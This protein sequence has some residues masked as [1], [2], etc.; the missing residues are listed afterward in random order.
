MAKHLFVGFGFGPIQSGLFA[1]EAF[2]SRRFERIVIAEIDSRLV[3]A[4][5]RAGGSYWV[6]I[7]A[8]DRIDRQRVE[9]VEIYNPNDPNDRAALQDALAGATEIC[10]SLPSVNFY[11][12]GSP[13]VADWIAEGL[14]KSAA[15]A[16]IVYTAEN[17]N[18][19]AEILQAAVQAKCPR[20]GRPVQ[21]LNTVIGK[22]SQVVVDAAYI[23]DKKLA[24]I[25]DGFPRA[26]LV[27]AFNKILVTQCQL[28]DFKP[29]ISVFI[30]KPDLL[31]F[32]E[33]K[34]YGHNAIHALLAYLAARR[35]LRSM[36]Q[37]AAQPDLMAIGRRAFIEQSGAA[38][39]AKYA[40]LGDPLFTPEGFKDYAEDLLAR[41]TNPQLDD[42]VERAAR[43]PMRKLGIS[44]RLFGTM[45]LCLEQSVKPLDLAIGAAG[46]LWYL[47]KTVDRKTLPQEL[48]NADA[49]KLSAG[50]IETALRWI[51][52]ADGQKNRFADAL[53]G[54]T[55]QAYPT[56]QSL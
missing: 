8:A 56:L 27:E 4:V 45:T 38:L 18:H 20:F 48:A 41:M 24:P 16:T 33:A 12:T 2:A 44:D 52:Q 11:T 3:E 46:G 30:E 53:V 54:L 55:Q 43:D 7:A 14:A 15:P 6:N 42:A 19:A 26:F 34:L 32:E 23:A 28:K 39:C 37:L 50:Q 10:T 9:G 51:W 25:A 13:S 47:L 36:A 40:K 31:P 5:R 17:N 1:Y 49:E 35:G 21:F 29:G 22:M